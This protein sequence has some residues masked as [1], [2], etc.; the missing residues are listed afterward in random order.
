M[1]KERLVLVV[2]VC[3]QVSTFIYLDSCRLAHYGVWKKTIIND[4]LATTQ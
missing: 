4:E 2:C 3:L 1:Q